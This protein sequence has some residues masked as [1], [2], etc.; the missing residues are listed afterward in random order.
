MEINDDVFFE[1]YKPKKNPFN[2]DAGWDGSMLETYGEELE[3]VLDAYRT[4][5]G[6]VWTVLDCDGAM[7]VGN[8]YH[9]VNRLGYIITEVPCPSGVDID[10]IDPDM[11]AMD[12]DDED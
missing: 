4:A 6:T 11:L 10:V 5:P 2:P 1:T 8:G 9:H 12:E 3:H 7:I